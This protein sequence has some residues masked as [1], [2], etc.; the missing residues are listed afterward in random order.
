MTE[1]YTCLNENEL[2]QGSVDFWSVGSSLR[3]WPRCDY[4]G[5]ER[6]KQYENSI[7]KYADSPIAPSWFD[8]TAAGER[9]DD[10]Y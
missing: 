3:S 4:H 1:R 6:L 9:W 7:E 5:M 10:D 8:P 2:C